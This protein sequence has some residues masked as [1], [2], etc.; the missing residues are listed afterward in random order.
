MT[1]FQQYDL[2]FFLKLKKG[3][4]KFKMWDLGGQPRFRDCWEKY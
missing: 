4:V 1:K 3:K 2:I